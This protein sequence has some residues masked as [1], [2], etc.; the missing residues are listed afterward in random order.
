[1]SKAI[2]F[3]SRKRYSVE[4]ML[5]LVLYSGWPKQSS[6]YSIHVNVIVLDE[7]WFGPQGGVLLYKPDGDA[8]RLA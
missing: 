2:F 5:I 8:R 6:S 1:M 4:S 7:R 3:A